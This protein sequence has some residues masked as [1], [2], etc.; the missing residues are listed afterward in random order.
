[1]PHCLINANHVCIQVQ[2]YL[3][4]KRLVNVELQEGEGAEQCGELLIAGLN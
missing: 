1:M 3:I 4:Y 2:Y